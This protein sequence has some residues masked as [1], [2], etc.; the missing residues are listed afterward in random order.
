[1]NNIVDKTDLE[2]ECDDEKETL[3]KTA[4]KL[5]RIKWIDVAKGICIIAIILGHM[6]QSNINKIV[7]T[8]HVTVFFIL[9]GYTLKNDK[10]NNSYVSKKFRKL[11]IQ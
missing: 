7:F 9:S 2:V 4:N 11:M 6:G 5:I 8:F 3:N 10:L 1:M